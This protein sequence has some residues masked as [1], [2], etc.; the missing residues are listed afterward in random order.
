[1]TILAAVIGFT[2]LA[3]LGWLALCAV[4]RTP[5]LSRMERAL[6]GFLLGSALLPFVALF[7]NV[8]GVELTRMVWIWLCAF[9]LVGLTLLCL[10][11]HRPFF[12][13]GPVLPDSGKTPLWAKVIVLL[14]GAWTAVKV[15]TMGVTFLVLTPTFLDDSLDN[16]NFRAKV[17][18]E[19]QSVQILLP[20]STP[21]QAPTGVSSYPPAVPLAKSFLA[22]LAGTWSEPLVNI[23]HLAWFV[24][25]LG[26][27]FC[28]L[29]RLTTA[30]WAA[31]GTCLLVSLPLLLMHGTNTYADVFLA[32]LLF[33]AVSTLC[34]AEANDGDARTS[35]LR[36]SAIA[37][38]ALVF[39]KNE[40]ILL[41]LPGIAVL[42]IL[43]LVRGRGRD[44][45]AALWAFW[46]VAAVLVPWVTYKWAHGMTFGNA[47]AVTGLSLGWQSAAPEAIVTQLFFEGNWMLLPLL[48]PILLVWRRSEAFGR[49]RPLAVFT[50]LLF[51]GQLPLYLFTS[52]SVE[53]TF[54][55]GY[56]RGL[57]HLAP[58]ATLLFCALLPGAVRSVRD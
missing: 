18:F 50:I 32:S 1:M 11:L 15:V 6:L 10:L 42:W 3:A 56:G 14:L 37:T 26:L 17:F 54:Q 49:L 29:R 8:L 47:K 21:E 51:V 43:L 22:T 58:I 27:F 46:I 5:V 25:L 2:L 31:L 55:T 35:L 52:L 7:A 30:W 19:T 44:L 9:L 16:W 40:A 12:A 45:S 13:R 48:L 4:E 28:A 57:I 38:A 24:C 34:L 39:T 20:G 41:Y 53:A 36:V 33:V 23:V